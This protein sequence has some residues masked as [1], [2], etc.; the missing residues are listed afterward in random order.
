[1]NHGEARRAR[2]NEASNRRARDA[3]ARLGQIED[4]WYEVLFT[5]ATGVLRTA[6]CDP[7][8]LR[9][10]MKALERRGLVEAADVLLQWRL[11]ERGL[12]RLATKRADPVFAMPIEQ[13]REYYARLGLA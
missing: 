8:K 10:A 2:A 4:D 7:R 13:V 9:A 11:T 1:M 3:R 12:L 5:L 6:W